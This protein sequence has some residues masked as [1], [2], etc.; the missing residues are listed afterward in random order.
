[1]PSK[2]IGSAALA[3]AVSVI[4]VWIASQAGVDI[5]PEVASSVTTVL[6]VGTGYLVPENTS[7]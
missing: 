4:L 3:A 2:K 6:T 5:P 7:E 1:M